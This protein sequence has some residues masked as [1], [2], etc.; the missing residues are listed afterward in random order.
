M[1]IFNG[2]VIT[3]REIRYDFPLMLEERS[4]DVWAY[5]LETVLAEKLETIVSRN[6][7]NTRMRDFYDIYILCQIHEENLS[8]PVLRDALIATAKKRGTF[9]QMKDAAAVF[10]EMEQSSTMEKLW[11]SYQK[12][13]LYASELFWYM[14]MSFVRALFLMCNL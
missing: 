6:V 10:D 4:I 11:N 5:N 7:S 3:P 9:I 1:S 14:V 12:K 13:Y 8:A 2:D